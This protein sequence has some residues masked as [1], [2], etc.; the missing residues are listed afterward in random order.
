MLVRISVKLHHCDAGAFVQLGV[1]TVPC[2][3]CVHRRY[4]LNNLAGNPHRVAACAC[5][6]D[7]RRTCIQATHT[8][9]SMAY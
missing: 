2:E 4:M 9:N 6:V 3:N 7:A 1:A 5:K 8:N